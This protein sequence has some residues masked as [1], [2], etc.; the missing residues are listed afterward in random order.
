MACQDI[1]CREPR[2]VEG[3]SIN[4]EV[5]SI[6]GKATRFPHTTRDR[7]DSEF[8]FFTNMF[9]RAQER[10]ANKVRTRPSKVA[11]PLMLEAT[12]AIPTKDI[13]EPKIFMGLGRSPKRKKANPMEKK[14]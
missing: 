2:I 3:P 5:A 14:T 10:A 7:A 11:S 13:K 1:F 4:K 6:N 9:P 12:R 8:T